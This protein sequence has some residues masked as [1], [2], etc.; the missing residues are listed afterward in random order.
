MPSSKKNSK[1]PRIVRRQV[2]K[3]EVVTYNDNTCAK[4]VKCKGFHQ[5]ELVGLLNV[6]LRDALLIQGENQFKKK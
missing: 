4:K 5:Y 1:K 3:L 2:Y 6:E